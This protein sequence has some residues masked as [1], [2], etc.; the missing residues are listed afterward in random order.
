MWSAAASTATDP[1][2]FYRLQ[3][4]GGPAFCRDEGNHRAGDR[5]L[6][7]CGPNCAKR[8]GWKDR[9]PHLATRNA[10]QYCGNDREHTSEQ[11]FPHGTLLLRLSNNHSQRLRAVTW[12]TQKTEAA[13]LRLV[14]KFEMRQKVTIGTEE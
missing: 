10:M 14:V 9:T 4:R 11:Q 8:S 1:S 12:V 2:D 7:H 3:A 13:G 5:C 6:S